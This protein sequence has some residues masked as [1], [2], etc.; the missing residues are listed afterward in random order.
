MGL[1][2][3]GNPNLI[4]ILNS[5]VLSLVHQLNVLYNFIIQVR[6]PSLLAERTSLD[7]RIDRD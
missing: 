4:E 6:E 2:G 7:A 5:F 3:N 1:P